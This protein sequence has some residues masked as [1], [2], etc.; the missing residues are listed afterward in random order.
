MLQ[1]SILEQLRSRRALYG[2]DRDPVRG[3]KSVDATDE[4][5]RLQPGVRK[6][7]RL[8]VGKKWRRVRAVL[9]AE[10]VCECVR[11]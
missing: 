10:V 6:V 11:K 9:M 5:L 7:K 8:G 1:C 2:R 3:K 4:T